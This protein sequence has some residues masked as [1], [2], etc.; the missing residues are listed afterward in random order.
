MKKHIALVAVLVSGSAA[1][2][3]DTE[4]KWDAE[5]RTRFFTNTNYVRNGAGLA[6]AAGTATST[7]EARDSVFRQRSSLGLNFKKGDNLSGRVRLLHTMAWGGATAASQPAQPTGT[8]ANSPYLQ[9][10]W[11]AWN[12]AENLTAKWGRSAMMTV[13]DGTV[14]STN[15]WIENPYAS[16]N[17]TFVGDYS[18]GRVGLIAVKATDSATPSAPYSSDP[19]TVFYGLSFDVKNLPDFLKAVNI[20]AIQQNVDQIA[21]GTTLATGSGQSLTRYG[22]TVSGDSMGLDYRL[23]YAMHSGKLVNAATTGNDLKGSMIDAGIGYTLADMKNLR[24][25]VKY[26]MDSGADNDTANGSETYQPFYYERHANAGRMDIIGWGNLTNIEVQLDMDLTEH[27]K[28]GVTYNMFSR[29]TDKDTAYMEAF[30]PGNGAAL[31]NTT[32][33]NGIVFGNT[34]KNIGTEIDLWLTHKYDNGLELTARYGMFTAGEYLKKSQGIG[35]DV[36]NATQAMLEARA[37]F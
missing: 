11:L 20:H 25:G 13:A 1:M 4:F 28:L 27:A 10:A 15:E 34:E 2:G 9:E 21:A 36:K 19:E 17:L 22:L 14:V 35:N 8:A 6:P 37:T 12:F 29:T 32:D 26:H 5:S 7:T 18:F 23:T 31:G 24:F 16:E 30:T 33:T 3:A